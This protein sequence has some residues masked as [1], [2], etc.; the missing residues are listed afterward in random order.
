MRQIRVLVVQ[1]VLPH[2]R[3]PFF[4][5]LHRE[6]GF[7]LTVA[8][9]H[10]ERL[11]SLTARE[12]P[13]FAT[14]SLSNYVVPILGGFVYQGGW[15]SLLKTRDY[16]CLILEFNVRILSNYFLTY[17]AKRRDIPCILWGHGLGHSGLSV[18][19]KLRY[20]MVRKCNA[21]VTYTQ[22]GSKP[23]LEQGISP[24]KIFIA[25]NT[26]DVDCMQRV[27]T[28]DPRNLILYIGRLIQQK[29][30]DV[31]IKA[32]A[33]IV[34]Q[35]LNSELVI[36]GDGPERQF[37]ERLVEE[38]NISS[39][40]RFTGTILDE[41]KLSVFFSRAMVYVCLGD[42][43]LG[44]VH[45][46]VYGVPVIVAHGAKHGPEIEYVRPGVNGLVLNEAAP[47]T[48]AA[49]IRALFKNKDLQVRLRAGA[50]LTARELSMDRMV[51]GF[52]EAIRYVCARQ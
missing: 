19:E 36:I 34:D 14:L 45:S 17:Q 13:K 12:D 41:K 50:E 15:S 39:H 44:V 33:S 16:D 10:I 23:F 28:E 46:F 2:Y 38:L 52:A 51:Q 27:K 37:L 47:E 25:P 24:E 42:V 30:L 40:C 7:D 43:G 20:Y 21:L 9:G 48:I 31:L 8:H 49:A 18:V 5:R 11:D 4:E 22:G 3:L 29:R 35:P 6:Q 32:F 26:L 1:R